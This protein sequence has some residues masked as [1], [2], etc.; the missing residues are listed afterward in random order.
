MRTLTVHLALQ[1]EPESTSGGVQVH[2]CLQLMTHFWAWDPNAVCAAGRGR[3]AECE[4][5]GH[6]GM[7]TCM[8]PPNRVQTLG[9]IPQPPTPPTTPIN[10][11]PPTH[12]HPTHTRCPPAPVELTTQVGLPLT[13]WHVAPGAHSQVRDPEVHSWPVASSGTLLGHWGHCRGGQGLKM[14]GRHTQLQAGRQPL[15]S[16]AMPS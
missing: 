2:R 5:H 7:P 13:N 14:A 16:Q 1:E 3:D 12:P 15:T 9:S 4:W 10:P 6:L 11:P 8:R